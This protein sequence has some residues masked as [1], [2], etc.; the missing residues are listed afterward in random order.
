[1]LRPLT[2]LGWVALLALGGCATPTDFASF[3]YVGKADGSEDAFAFAREDC[4]W[5]SP[6]VPI[7]EKYVY[8]SC[9]VEHGWIARE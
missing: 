2:S 9:M 4:R 7:A 6:P 3:R 8:R 5:K 1:M